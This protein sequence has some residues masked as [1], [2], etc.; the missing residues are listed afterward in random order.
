MGNELQHVYEFTSREDWIDYATTNM[1]K[2]AAQR[3]E[4][5]GVEIW[6]VAKR[7]IIGKWSD[8]INRGYIEEYRDDERLLK[9]STNET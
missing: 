5:N 3:H 2:I 9:D 8:D 6:L 7:G 1:A 4:E